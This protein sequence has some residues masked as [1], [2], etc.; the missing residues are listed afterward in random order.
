MPL[1]IGAVPGL[2]NQVMRVRIL[3]EAPNI[4]SLFQQKPLTKRQLG[5]IIVT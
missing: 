3:P 4:I 2:L 5:H 1:L